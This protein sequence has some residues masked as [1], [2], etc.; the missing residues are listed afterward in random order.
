MRL[1]EIALRI[2]CELRGA[3][4]VEIHRIMPIQE[5]GPGDLTF[6]ANPKYRRYLA[7]TKASAVIL[8]RNEPEIPLPSLRA[9]DPYEAFA[10]AV[11]LFFTPVPT[12]EGIH[13]TAVI[14]PSAEL[15]PDCTIGPYCVIGPG[16]T[17]GARGRLE[18]HVVLY[19]EVKI[20]DDFHAHSHVV[21]RE[22]VIIGHR[23]TL[24]PG[25]VIGGDGFG[26][27]L[28]PDGVARRITQAGTV[29]LEDDVEV[30]ANTT[31]DR[32]AIGATR[33]RRGAKLDNLVMVA[34]GCTIGEGTAIAAQTGLSGST[35]VGRFVRLG[36]Q[37]GAAGHLSIGD[38][39]QVA[40]QSGVHNDVPAGATYGGTPAVE[41]RQWRRKH[42]A[43]QRLPEALQRLRR[44]ERQMEV[45]VAR[46]GRFDDG[47]EEE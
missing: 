31:I 7:S 6:L 38:G 22:R 43:L 33:V 8:H 35:Q 16:V 4:D 12:W 3:G 20:G 34:H 23:V 27:V 30:G 1:D 2:G 37:V 40:A 11:D 47:R 29:I 32:A 15:G 5:A 10:R 24:Q 26:F 44:L 46:A 25:C 45:L 39:A 19:P 41:I 17:L 18:A 21:V 13:P 28:S 42:A 36:G 9:D 14:H